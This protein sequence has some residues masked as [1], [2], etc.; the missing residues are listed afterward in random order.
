MERS[1]YAGILITVLAS[2]APA[3]PVEPCRG[4]GKTPPSGTLDVRVPPAIP[5]RVRLQTVVTL[6]ADAANDVTDIGLNAARDSRGRIFTYTRD[7]QITV[8]HPDGKLA[9][10]VGRRGAGPG[11]FGI[12]PLIPFVSAGDSLFIYD[13]SSRRWS[14]FSKNL[15]LVRIVSASG[16]QAFPNR[17]ALLTNGHLLTGMASDATRRTHFGILEISAP[18]GRPGPRV[19]SSFGPLSSR[20]LTGNRDSRERL[21][22]YAGGEVFWAVAPTPEAGAY[23]VEEWG[24]DGVLRRSFRRSASW[25]RNPPGKADE[26]SHFGVDWIHV[27]TTGLAYVLTYAP[28]GSWRPFKDAAERGKVRDDFYD[29]QMDVLDVRNGNLVARLGPMS[30]RRARGEMPSGFFAG[31]RDAYFR[32]ENADGYRTLTVKRLAMESDRP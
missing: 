3:Q 2:A 29:V 30:L 24:I 4:A 12:G 21:I 9:T 23:T 7:G 17:V 6:S 16:A 18:A 11:E 22:A 13:G 28:N 31:T 25:M 15:N 19:I 26:G 14:V 20:D 8:W 27:D 5:C 32:G 1:F 10:T